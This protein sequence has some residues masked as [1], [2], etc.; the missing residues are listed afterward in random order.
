V[1]DL[2]EQ[3]QNRLSPEARD[4]TAV[5]VCAGSERVICEIGTFPGARTTDRSDK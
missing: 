4:G 5:W 1:A 3:L 2:A